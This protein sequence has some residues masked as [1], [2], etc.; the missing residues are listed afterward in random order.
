MKNARTHQI[1]PHVIFFFAL[2]HLSRNSFVVLLCTNG[3]FFVF[4]LLVV[5][6]QSW[7]WYFTILLMLLLLLK[8]FFCDALKTMHRINHKSHDSVNKSV[9]SM[10]KTNAHSAVCVCSPHINK[11]HDDS[12]LWNL[13]CMYVCLLMTCSEYM[14]L[15]RLRY[16]LCCSVLYTKSCCQRNKDQ[17][18]IIQLHSC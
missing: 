1:N 9:K 12:R 14:C 2:S 13:V 15:F 8:R 16:H 3:K 10:L 5:Q 7:F 4:R 18:H 17:I 11:Q 6:S